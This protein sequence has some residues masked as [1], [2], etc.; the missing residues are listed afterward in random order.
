[1]KN[2]LLVIGFLAVVSV[3]VY[4]ITTALDGDDRSQNQES[5]FL[6]QWMLSADNHLTLA[7]NALDREAGSS[8][9]RQIEKAIL[10]IKLVQT[11]TDS[12]TASLLEE[13]VNK[14][15]DVQKELE[16]EEMNIRS[17]EVAAAKALN[18]LAL[19]HLKYSEQ[20]ASIG[21]EEQATQS[22]RVAITHLQNTIDLTTNAAQKKAEMAVIREL[23]TLLD[24]L[25]ENGHMDNTTYTLSANDLVELINQE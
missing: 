9:A 6:S 4:F 5:F 8:E 11:K 3:G 15:M 14:L 10:A 19:V 18:S 13:A 21:K 1:M 25:V 12:E 16:Q 17:F 20:Q 23:K 22:I 24:S 2:I 7:K